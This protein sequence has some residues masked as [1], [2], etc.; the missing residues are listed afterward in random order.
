MFKSIFQRLLFT[1]AAIIMAV[2]GMLAVFMTV[3]FNVYLFEQKQ[4]QLLAAGRQM[5]ELAG[6]FQSRQIDRG[7]LQ[8]AAELLG[9]ITGS[10]IY[11]LDSRGLDRLKHLAGQALENPGFGRIA[12][13]IK[14]VLAGETLVRKKYFSD[15]FNMNMVLVG[16]P[17]YEQGTVRGVV[18]LLSPLDQINSTLFRVY[19]II[20]GT[21]AASL[22]FATMVI[23]FVSRR[24]SR[25]IE[26]IQTTA[27][28]IAEGRFD[29]D[30]E[31]EG[32]D[33]VAQLT[34]TFNYMKNRLK[35]IEA[36]RRE[37]IANVSHELRTPL[38]SI[39]GFIQGIL[40]G[41]IEPGE[42]KKY[43]KRAYDEAG[44]LNR[45]VND[46]LQLARLQA[47]SVKLHREKVD[48]GELVREV[49]EEHRFWAGQ[50]NVSLHGEAAG[51]NL[52]ALADRD[53]L[54]QVFLNLVH[55]AVNY[56]CDGGQVLVRVLREEGRL[57][58]EVED[59]GIGIPGDE[60]AF[61]FEKFHRVER[62]ERQQAP[63]SGLGL[64]IARELVELHGGSIQA[65]SKTGRGTRMT[66]S[67]P[68]L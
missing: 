30:V 1:Y 12:E 54:K 10:R 51:D 3:F 53:R 56:S 33:E 42:Q 52:V 4:G 8:Q 14:P 20:W 31:P 38:T 40:E 18:L 55:N 23:Y 13:D 62:P 15:Q 5:E 43:L 21:A 39:R 27:A 61:V 60:L 25:P 59:N 29:A 16:M 35:Q 45:L 47:G 63:G 64:S 67:L 37:L 41:V 24:I 50:R 57:T 28:S 58:I 36:M 34:R 9:T 66:V 46:L 44:R 48:V 6:R 7:E 49:I 65:R 32:S 26:R 17:F 22:A 11:V 19:R 68:C 2:V